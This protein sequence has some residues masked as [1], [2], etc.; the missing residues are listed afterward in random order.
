MQ[1]AI[2][3]LIKVKAVVRPIPQGGCRL[4]GE[5]LQRAGHDILP[6]PNVFGTMLRFGEELGAKLFEGATPPPLLTVTTLIDDM[7]VRHLHFA[8]EIVHPQ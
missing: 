8:P 5:E 3:S 4:I 1:I 2:H 7:L 6:Q